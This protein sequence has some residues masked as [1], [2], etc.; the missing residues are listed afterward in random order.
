MIFINLDGSSIDYM[1]AEGVG[2]DNGGC[3]PIWPFTGFVV[4]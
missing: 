3:Y 4:Q 1:C 2:K